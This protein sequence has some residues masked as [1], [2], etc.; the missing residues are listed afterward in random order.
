MTARVLVLGLDAA[1]FEVINPLIAAGRLPNLARLMVEG[2]ACPLIST[3]P[4][5]TPLAWTSCRTG[6]N[7]GKHG[8]FDFWQVKDYQWV[9]NTSADIKVPAV[10]KILSRRGRR[11]CTVNVP[12][13]Y[14][15]QPVNGLCISG[16]P[17]PGVESGYTYPPGLRM[18]LLARLGDF[19]L[20]GNE[21]LDFSRP[22]QTIKMLYEHHRRRRRTTL[23]LLEKERWDYFMVVFTI[24]DK[25]QHAFWLAREMYQQGSENPLAQRFGPVI[26]QCYELLDETVGMVVRAAGEECAILVVSDHGFGRC[27]AEMYPNI[28]LDQQGYF[29]LRTAHKLWARQIVWSPRPRVV[30]GS[31]R[32]RVDWRRTRAFSG[33][34]LET[35][36]LHFNL[37][38][39]HPQ[40]V[41]S[42]GAEAENLAAELEAQL[43][44]L[45]TP[46]GEPLLQAVCRPE[47]LYHG[48]HTH[49]APDLIL[50]PADP[51]TRVMGQIAGREYYQPI[52]DLYQS[53]G[54][55]RPEGI[56]IAWGA[57][58]AHPLPAQASIMDIAPTAL[59]LL[60]EDVPTYMDGRPLLG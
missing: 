42:P 9:F 13:S 49:L 46:A 50:L 20:D 56:L 25:L 54:N 39:R 29:R 35:K 41:V 19:D 40:G 3:T 10:E 47:A 27:R 38:G 26:D 51:A 22:A 36:G 14:P 48:A 16:L 52:T 24:A 12:L 5:K 53:A 21:D 55:H 30:V 33:L 34:Y 11:V 8:I 17:T 28:W 57:A 4:D 23:Y 2:S 18:E 43:L 6:V 32:R 1:T 60:G 59:A 15:P 31:P 44:A 58:A 45:A 7:P 37:R